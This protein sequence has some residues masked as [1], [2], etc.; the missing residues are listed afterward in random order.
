MSLSRKE[1]IYFSHF[2]RL[3]SPKSRCW[4]IWFLVREHDLCLEIPSCC[5]LTWQREKSSHFFFFLLWASVPFMRAL[6][7]WPN[8]LQLAPT[9]PNTITLGMRS[10]TYEFWEDTNIQSTAPT[11]PS[12]YSLLWKTQGS[13][14]QL[15][16]PPNPTKLIWVTGERWIQA[17]S[18]LLVIFPYAHLYFNI[19]KTGAVLIIISQ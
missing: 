9:S 5:M 11:N 8:F 17:S 1:N 6:L 15:T 18:F 7:L 16:F 4:L 2:W 3:A 12:I 10:S 13:Q 19:F 14:T